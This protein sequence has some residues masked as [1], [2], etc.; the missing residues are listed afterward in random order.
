MSRLPSDGDANPSPVTP[1]DTDSLV[2]IS[3][4]AQNQWQEQSRG[5]GT[6]G[7]SIISAT[8]TIHSRIFIR[9]LLSWID[10]SS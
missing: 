3:D 4:D 2:R 1:V 10:Q 7:E 8:E 5:R 9:S 6:E